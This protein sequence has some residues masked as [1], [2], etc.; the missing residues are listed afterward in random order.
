MRR[1]L[2]NRLTRLETRLSSI[3]APPDP[4]EEAERLERYWRTQEA[5]L[6]GCKLPPVL[7]DQCL[8][9]WRTLIKYSGA[10][11]ELIRDGFFKEIDPRELEVWAEARKIPRKLHLAHKED[12]GISRR[13]EGDS[14]AD[15]FI[16]RAADK[17]S[18]H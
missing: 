1:D 4:A 17:V 13:R 2:H 12:E 9:F 18:F 7:D 10:F 16:H 11:E 6:K 8:G 14:R 5:Y 3:P 15:A